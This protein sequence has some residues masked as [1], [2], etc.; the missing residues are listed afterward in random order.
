MQ[1]MIRQLIGLT[2][3]VASG[4]AAASVITLNAT[5][6]D[7]QASHPNFQNGGP[8]AVYTGLVGSTLGLDGKPVYVGGTTLTN[9]TDFNQWYNN[10]AGVNQAFSISLAAAE[11]FAGSGIYSYTN[12]S[13]FPID[14]LGFG[15]E[16]RSHNYHFTTEIN[17]QF[18]YVGG[19]TFSFRGDDDVWVYINN[20]LVVDLGGVHSAANGSVNI[21]SLGLT[22]GQNY[23]LDIFHAERQTTQSNFNF[24]TSALLVQAS[25]PSGI[26]LLGLS[27]LGLGW[28][29]K[30]QHK[31]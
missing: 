1:K 25:A 14:G 2:M 26:A 13:Y 10:V 17:S 16:G 11:T 23:S 8:Y 6:R 24:T 31:N 21:D 27:L 9:A 7:F 4:L 28:S 5:V 19:E 30:R 20:Q 15:N 12:S 3:L 22:V 18:T 29:R